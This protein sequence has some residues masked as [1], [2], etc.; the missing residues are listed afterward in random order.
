MRE[1]CPK[2][3]AETRGDKWQV[4]VPVAGGP[5]A[6]GDHPKHVQVPSSV[7]LSPGFPAHRNCG[8][9]LGTRVGLRTRKPQGGPG[10]MDGIHEQAQIPSSHAG[11]A[12]DRLSWAQP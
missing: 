3:W 7:A 8:D 10:S 12:A 5:P 4:W 6:H 9:Q 2:N 1:S 11:R